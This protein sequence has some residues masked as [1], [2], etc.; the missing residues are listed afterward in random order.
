MAVNTKTDSVLSSYSRGMYPTSGDEAHRFMPQELL[1]I[2]TF[3]KTATELTITV[4]DSAVVNPKRGMVR[5]AVDPWFPVSSVTTGDT[6]LVVFTG[7]A[8]ALVKGVI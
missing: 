5:Y 4:A 6:G 7:S 1:K 2:D 8:W 3:C